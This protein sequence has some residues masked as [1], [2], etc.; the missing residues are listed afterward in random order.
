MLYWTGVVR[1]P[2]TAKEEIHN[3]QL[4]I[5]TL[6]QDV[7]NASLSH[8]QGEHLVNGDRE[9][10]ANLLEVFKG[11]LEYILDKIESDTSSAGKTVTKIVQILTLR[12]C[13]KDKGQ[14]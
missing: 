12:Q 6:S 3:A 14:T 9:T 11:L 7:L 10:I 1:N 13:V 5:D 4:V 8:I 2:R